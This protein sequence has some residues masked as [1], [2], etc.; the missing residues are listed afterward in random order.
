MYENLQKD[1]RRQLQGVTSSA[2]TRYVELAIVNDPAMIEEYESDYAFL[3]EKT[4]SIVATLQHY[5][6]STDFGS[7]I[8]NIQMVLSGIIY[9]TDFGTL[10]AP[11]LSCSGSATEASLFQSNPGANYCEVQYASYLSNFQNYRASNL[12]DYDNSQL[13]SYYDF[14]SSVIGY[15]S[16]PGMC[17]TSSSGGIEQCTYD[18]E[19]NGNIV[20]HEMGHNFNMQ[21]DGNGNACSPSDYIMAS[22]GSPYGARPDSFSSCSVTYAQTFFGST[23]Y[24]N[25]LKCL[26]NKPTETSFAVCRNGFV[27]EGMISLTKKF[28]VS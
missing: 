11:T 23:S 15:A 25:T 14:A 6:L 26:D 5:Y 12:K 22:V 1:F 8:G 9:I 28:F 19:Y 27:E 7:S 16:L 20:A 18:D 13:F 24:A 10:S 2:A 4:I 17:I 3:Q 21:H